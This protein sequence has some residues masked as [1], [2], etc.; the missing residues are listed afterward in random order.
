MAFMAS[1]KTRIRR[2][3]LLGILFA[4][5]AAPIWVWLQDAPLSP[6]GWHGYTIG[7]DDVMTYSDGAPVQ[8]VMDMWLGAGAI[9]SK[10]QWQIDR[11][12][13][14]K[15]G[16]LIVGREHRGVMLCNTAGLGDEEFAVARRL[17]EA[18]VDSIYRR[19]YFEWAW[20]NTQRLL[21][22]LAVVFALAGATWAVRWVRK[23]Q[24][25]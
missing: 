17:F 19:Y 1:P 22:L 13:P 11:C 14:S 20:L 9:G 23:G 15:M 25:T 5:V 8:Y 4:L 24:P 16:S 6:T 3:V 21:F 12:D 18:E 2:F 10:V 7:R